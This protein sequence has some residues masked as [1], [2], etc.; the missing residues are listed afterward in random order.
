MSTDS[1][2]SFSDEI[3]F[4][5]TSDEVGRVDRAIAHRF[6]ESSRRRLAELF[7]AGG[8]RIDGRRARKGDRVDAG[9][10]VVLTSAPPTPGDQSPQPDPE[11]AARLTVLHV[12]DDVVAISK[13]AGMP[14]QPLRAGELGTVASALASLY[15]ECAATSDDPRDGGLVHRLDIGTSGVLVAARTRAS[16]EALRRAFGG[17]AIDKEYLALTWGAP[18]SSSCDAPL[19]QR[20]KKVA[21]DAAEGLAAHTEWNVDQVLGAWRLMR[22]HATTGR[23]HQI[24]AHL[25]YCGAPIAGDTLYGG[26]E[27]PG[28]LGFF[29]HAAWLRLPGGTRIDAPLPPDR[30][31][32]LAR[33]ATP[34]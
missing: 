3:R 1:H 4:V 13:P 32:T 16:W 22:C 33:L 30:A 29:L 21:V 19:A 26:P 11:A 20:G 6:P 24:R 9:V 7:D 31:D 5:V 27:L 12:D 10:E 15:P 17:G 14:S 18:V 2:T 28:V 23:M 34:L 25:A 8:V